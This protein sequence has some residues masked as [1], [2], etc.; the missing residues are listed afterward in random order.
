MKSFE[1][2]M[3]PKTFDAIA[4]DG[5]EVRVLL[6][7]VDGGMAHFLLHPGCTSKALMHQTVEEIWYF[8]KGEGEMWRK[9]GNYEEIIKVKPGMSITIPLG[10]E[11]QFRNTGQ[12]ELTAIGITMPPWPGEEEALMVEG[13]WKPKLKK[14]YSKRSESHETFNKGNVV[15]SAKPV[16]SRAKQSVAVEQKSPEKEK[17]KLNMK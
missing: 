13:I 7:L 15:K 2:K 6:S 4:P 10:T 8:L 5:S 9:H 1:S 12:K 17:P 11:F 3:I 14:G 16:K